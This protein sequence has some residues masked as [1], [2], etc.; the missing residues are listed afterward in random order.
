[1]PT[2]YSACPTDIVEA[3]IEVVWTLLT[4]FSGWGDFY[5]VRVKRVEPPGRAVVGQRMLG[6]SGP[7]LLHLRVSFEFTRID[8]PRRQLEI[9]IRLPLGI[10]VHESLDCVRIDD[11]RCRV[12]YHCNFAFPGRF[13]GAMLRFLLSRELKNG[14]ADSLSRLKRA[15][16]QAYRDGRAEQKNPV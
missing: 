10:K 16:E 9:D 7:R 8:E 1:M 5:D 13:R 12:N 2:T 15:A 14:P 4:N 11:T 6:E 3:P